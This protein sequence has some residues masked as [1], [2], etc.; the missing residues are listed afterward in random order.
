MTTQRIVSIR[1]TPVNHHG[2]DSK[3]LIAESV[4]TLHCFAVVLIM[5]GGSMGWSK[6]GGVI[7]AGGSAF[8]DRM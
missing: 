7:E 8:K 5:Y 3:Q 1:Y 4:S 6:T 2:H